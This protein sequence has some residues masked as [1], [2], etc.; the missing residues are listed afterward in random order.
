MADPRVKWFLVKA[1]NQESIHSHNAF[2]A[3]EWARPGSKG[4]QNDEGSKMMKKRREEAGGERKALFFS[5][6]GNSPWLL[7]N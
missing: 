6:Q 2:A 3:I 1:L 7:S 5:R 4:W